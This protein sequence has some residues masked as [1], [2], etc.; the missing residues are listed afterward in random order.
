MHAAERQ[1]LAGLGIL[2]T[3][4]ARQREVETAIDREL[5]ARAEGPLR[6]H[7]QG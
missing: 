6:E 2:I 5:R 7:E 1:A 3:N 4:D